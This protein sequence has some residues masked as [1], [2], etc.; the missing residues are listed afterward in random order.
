[1]AQ[2]STEAKSAYER[3][4][5]K[6]KRIANVEKA[7]GLL[8]WDQQVIMPDE[9]TPARS[10]QMSTLSALSHELMTDEE[11]GELL[12]A[13][14]ADD[15][16]DEQADVLREIRRDYERA[17]R[18]PNDLVEEISATSSE[19]ITAWKEAKAED[20]FETFAPY[21][22][23]HVE[24][25][26]KY[27]EHI[28]P[29]RDPYEVLFEDYEPCLPLEQAEEI[30]AEVREVL[31]SMIEDIRESDEELAVDA[32][33]GEFPAGKQ[34]EL[35]RDALTTLGYPW[36]RGRLDTAPHPFSSGTQFD[37]RVTTRYDESDP[38]GSLFSTIHEFGHALYTLGLPDEHYATPLGED[39]DLS[40]HESQSRLW[41]NHVGRSRA[42]WQHFLPTFEEHFPETDATVEDA[43]EAANQVY[44]DNLIRVEADELTYHLHIVIRFELERELVSGDLSV[45]DVP[46]AWN[47]KYE[48]YLGIRPET[49][50]EGCLQDIHW[51][52]GNFG[53]FPTYSLGS[54]MAAQLFAAAEEDIEN[55]DEKIADGEFDDLREWLREN[56]HQHGRRYET[57]DLVKRATGDDFT[58]DEFIDYVESKY[59][60]LYDL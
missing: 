19:A 29:D 25:K 37:A 53:Y 10:Q 42:F 51:A 24:L 59:G 13:A 35:A 56:I 30:L 12:E 26:R 40:V 28:D 21:L 43:Y 49:D 54:I 55:L 8:S 16:T 41:E 17:V 20:D 60:E 48:S 45:E 22:E 52:Y 39:R 50:S 15:P 31:V 38:L 5:T 18:V 2:S 33:E 11:F 47:D 6:Y 14:E 57:N 1:M 27:A 9:G 23:K 58:A 7:G 32:F 3:L 46:E 4:L 34:E 44:E 36:E